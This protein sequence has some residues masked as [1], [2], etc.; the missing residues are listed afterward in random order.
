MSNW[1][2]FREFFH[3]CCFWKISSKCTKLHEFLNDFFQFFRF[4]PIFKVLNFE[5]LF[6]LI[7]FSIFVQFSILSNFDNIASRGRLKFSILFIFQMWSTGKWGSTSDIQSIAHSCQID[8]KG[9]QPRNTDFSGWHS[10]LF[11]RNQSRLTTSCGHFQPLGTHSCLLSLVGSDSWSKPHYGHW[12]TYV[13]WWF[14]TCCPQPSKS[15]LA[16]QQKIQ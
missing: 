14:N 15:G 8:Q 13:F 12:W 11:D 4:C 2:E 10:G 3:D 16:M 6:N 7:Q 1:K 5:F 9:A